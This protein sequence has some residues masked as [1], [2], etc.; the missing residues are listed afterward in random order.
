MQKSKGICALVVG[1]LVGRMK[2]NSENIDKIYKYI[3]IYC[4]SIWISMHMPNI[5]ELMRFKLHL[6]IYIHTEYIYIYIVGF[7]LN[8]TVNILEI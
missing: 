5:R 8:I 2:T 4:I 6:Y 7:E 1:V 3:Y